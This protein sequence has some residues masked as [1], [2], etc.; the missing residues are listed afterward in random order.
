MRTFIGIP[1][2]ASDKI[3]EVLQLLSGFK[4]IKPVEPENIHVTLKFLGNIEEEN[5][6]EINKVLKKTLRSFQPFQLSI[7]GTGFFPHPGNPR[8]IWI[9]IEEGKEILEEMFK[10][11]EDAL[12]SFPKEKRGFVPHITVGRVKKKEEI[13]RIAEE[14]KKFEDV[15]FGTFNIRKVI[16]FKSKLTPQGPIYTPLREYNL[17]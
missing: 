14:L 6:K 12:D 8:V 5:V 3:K 4:G 9:G 10:A 11:I 7:K 16:F 13:K 1:I 17:R 2:P 15:H